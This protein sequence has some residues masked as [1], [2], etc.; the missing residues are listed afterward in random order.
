METTEQKNTR[1]EQS[2]VNAAKSK[3][4]KTAEGQAKAKNANNKPAAY[5]AHTTAP[6]PLPN[7][8]TNTSA[9]LTTKIMSAA[10]PL[11]N[12][13]PANRPSRIGKIRKAWATTFS[14]QPPDTKPPQE[15]PAQPPPQTPPA[16]PEKDQ[17][18]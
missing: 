15:P 7:P 4:A 3:G 18:G 5:A 17:P 1:A 8:R 13:P 12:F 10:D 14:S 9:I 6:H 16:S 11:R 2:R